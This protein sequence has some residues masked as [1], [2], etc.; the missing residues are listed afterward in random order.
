MDDYDVKRELVR[1]IVEGDRAQVNLAKDKIELLQGASLVDFHPE[2]DI[3]LT[4]V[5]LPQ[6]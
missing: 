4:Q 2:P 6:G 3:I 1:Q 5:E